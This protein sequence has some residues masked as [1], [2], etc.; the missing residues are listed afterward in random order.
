MAVLSPYFAG[1]SPPAHPA[2]TLAALALA[3][4]PLKREGLPTSEKT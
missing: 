4:C 3:K 1:P 2:L